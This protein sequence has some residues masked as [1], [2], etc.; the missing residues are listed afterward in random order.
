VSVERRVTADRP[1]KCRRSFA[2]FIRMDPSAGGRATHP[3]KVALAD[4]PGGQVPA[5]PPH[6]VSCCR[7]GPLYLYCDVFERAGT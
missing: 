5:R 1:R 4:D 6:Y 2:Y 3:F 7:H